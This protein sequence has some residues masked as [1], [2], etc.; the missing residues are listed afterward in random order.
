MFTSPEGNPDF[1]DDSPHQGLQD[2]DLPF[3][4][5]KFFVAPSRKND[6]DRGFFLFLNFSWYYQAT[7]RVHRFSLIQNVTTVA[8]SAYFL[9]F[10]HPGQA[11]GSDLLVTA[12]MNGVATVAVWWHIKRQHRVRL[13]QAS[14]LSLAKALL[15]AGRPT[16]AFGLCYSAL[17]SVSLPLC[18]WLLG[19]RESGYYRSAA[20]IVLSLQVFLAYFAYMLNPRIVAWRHEAPGRFRARVLLVAGGTAA[21]GVVVFGLLWLVRDVVIRV[22]CGPEFMPAA[23]LLPVLVFAKF[24]A[25]ASGVLIWALFASGRDW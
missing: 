6:D 25:V 10:F 22:L 19:Q 2:L 15:V 14:A 24:L 21:V 13:I 4:S 5:Q 17:T 18:Y 11:A 20:M 23:A 16:W 12:L 7:E 1:I 3:Q 9:V 8:T